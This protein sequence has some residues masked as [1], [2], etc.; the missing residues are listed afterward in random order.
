MPETHEHIARFAKSRIYVWL[1]E[2]TSRLHDG[3]QGG[4]G[5]YVPIRQTVTSTCGLDI[6]LYTHEVHINTSCCTHRQNYFIWY[7]RS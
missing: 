4:T 1:S 2:M 7:Q 6:I 5:L 3:E